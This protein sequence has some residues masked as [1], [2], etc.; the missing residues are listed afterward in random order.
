[1][2]DFEF[3]HAYR[4]ML[5]KRKILPIEMRSTADIRKLSYESCMAALRSEIYIVRY[6]LHPTVATR[7]S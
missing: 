2:I 3:D 7:T 1:M 6:K 5:K 4:W